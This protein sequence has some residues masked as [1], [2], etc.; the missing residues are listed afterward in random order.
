MVLTLRLLGRLDG[1]EAAAREALAAV[2]GHAAM[3]ET[4]T[5]GLREKAVALKN[6]LEERRLLALCHNLS[7]LAGRP[8]VGILE[9]CTRA[10]GRAA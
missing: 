2:K 9:L 10:A 7:A 5:E 8:S 4:E 1:S 3:L 6:A